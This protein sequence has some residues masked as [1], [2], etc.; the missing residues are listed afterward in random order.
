[1]AGYATGQRGYFIVQF[2]GP[3]ME[4][5]KADVAAA[6]AELLDYIPDFAYTARMTPEAAD[7]IAA[8]DSVAWVGSF[9]PA[10][11]LDPALLRAGAATRAYRVRIERGA[12]VNATVNQIVGAGAEVVGRDGNVIEITASRGALPPPPRRRRKTW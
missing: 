3:V 12:N 1:M 7:R 10:Y 5:W 11:K 4:A 2:A 6:G 9:H 8:L